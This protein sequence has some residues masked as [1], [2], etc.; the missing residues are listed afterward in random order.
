MMRPKSS[1]VESAPAMGEGQ[2]TTSAA[3]P[4]NG[5]VKLTSPRFLAFLM[6]Q[7]LGAA[8]DNALKITLVLFMISAVSG[9]ARQ[10]R[11]SSLATALFPIPFLLFSPLAGYLADRFAKHRVLLWTK[12]PE[13]LVMALAAAGFVLHSIP[14]LFVVLFLSATPAHF[15]LLRSMGFCRK[16]SPMIKSHRPMASWS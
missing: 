7:A 9:Q 15:S 1:V 8:N 13:I 3:L 12:S 11:Y 2:T 14:F 4:G 6:A 5:G 16:C 10:V